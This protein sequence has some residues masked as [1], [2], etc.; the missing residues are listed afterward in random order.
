MK[1]SYISRNIKY[2]N[3]IFIKNDIKKKKRYP[4]DLFLNEIRNDLEYTFG[5]NLEF[6]KPD[7]ELIH[8]DDEK[9][10]KLIEII[11]LTDITVSDNKLEKHDNNH[12]FKQDNKQF[13]KQDNKQDNKINVIYLKN[14]V[15]FKRKRK[16][17]IVISGKNYLN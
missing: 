4:D 16:E 1:S 5:K 8:K 2:L 10:I 11:T 3:F 15:N 7:N 9:K 17:T 14:D 6:I 13:N 12:D